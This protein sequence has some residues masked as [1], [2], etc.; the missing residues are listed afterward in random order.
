MSSVLLLGLNLRP[1][2]LQVRGPRVGMHNLFAG[3]VIDRNME[4]PMHR[5]DKG[6]RS[7]PKLSTASKKAN[8]QT[9][10]TVVYADF[11]A[12]FLPWLDQ[13]DWSSI[14]PIRRRSGGAGNEFPN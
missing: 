3:L 5:Q 2:H 1:N 6:E 9:P 14:S 11:E 13:L 4:L 7:R 12:A 10:N 8:G